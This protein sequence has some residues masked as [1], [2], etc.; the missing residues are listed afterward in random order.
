[1]DQPEGTTRTAVAVDAN[2][3]ARREFQG[4]RWLLALI[5]GGV[6]RESAVRPR[7]APLTE[8][9]PVDPLAAPVLGSV[10]P[11]LAEITTRCSD[12]VPHRILLTEADIPA[13]PGWPTGVVSQTP[14]GPAGGRCSRRCGVTP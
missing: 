13:V 2:F 1:M 3:A 10:V 8:R 6:R 4:P 9:E 14:R 12:D 7:H 11:F 5:C